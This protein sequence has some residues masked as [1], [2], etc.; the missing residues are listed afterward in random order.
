MRKK[1]CW[2]MST[3]HEWTNGRKGNL[4]TVCL[5]VKS[6]IRAKIEKTLSECNFT[7]I[8]SSESPT[9]QNHAAQRNLACKANGGQKVSGMSGFS[10]QIAQK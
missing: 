5:R 2:T 3:N 9:S 4:R 10:M 1:L 7:N 8:A 6:Q